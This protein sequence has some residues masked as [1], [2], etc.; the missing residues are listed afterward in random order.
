MSDIAWQLPMPDLVE[1]SYLTTFFG[2]KLWDDLVWIC[3]A[4]DDA[5]DLPTNQ[6]Y[7]TVMEISSQVL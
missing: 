3:V 7:N 2:E 1:L 5:Q 4:G 6:Q